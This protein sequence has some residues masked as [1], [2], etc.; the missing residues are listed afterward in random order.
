MRRSFPVRESRH[1]Y[2]IAFILVFAIAASFRTFGE[3]RGVLI[4]I[5]LTITALVLMPRMKTDL[6]A[7]DLESK[8]GPGI[9]AGALYS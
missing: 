1:P 6:Q 3:A 4:F 8:K 5:A 2:V 9:S 7:L